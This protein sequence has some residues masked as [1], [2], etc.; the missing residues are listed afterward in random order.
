M[1]VAK[2]GLR[3]TGPNYKIQSQ[4]ISNI[5]EQLDWIQLGLNNLDLE[6]RKTCLVA[7]IPIWFD[8]ALLSTL[9][10]KDPDEVQGLIAH[11]ME[12]PFVEIFSEECYRIPEYSRVLLLNKVWQENPEQYRLLNKRAAEYCAKQ[13]Q[14]DANWVIITIYHNL[15]AGSIGAIDRFVQQGIEW[16]GNAN[17]YKYAEE[18]VKLIITAIEIGCVIGLS[19]SWTYIFQ[20]RLNIIHEDY[21]Q[22]IANLAQA[23]SQKTDNSF[24]QSH[25]VK[26]LGDVYQIL[27]VQYDLASYE[28]EENSFEP[29]LSSN[30]TTSSTIP[31]NNIDKANLRRLI[32]TFFDITDLRLLCFDLQLDYESIGG[33]EDKRLKVVELISYLEKRERLMELIAKCEEMRPHLEWRA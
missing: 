33:G 1:P 3:L 2:S 21:A 18:L 27:Q 25:A 29:S 23:L 31:F 32:T 13:D 28:L 14:S 19:A 15:I 30:K 17:S 11:L 4:M 12:L 24:V 5:Q 16:L 10:E 26:T 8:S 20:S 22:S 7:A 9:L 6:I